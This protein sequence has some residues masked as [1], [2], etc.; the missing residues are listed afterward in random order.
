[1]DDAAANCSLSN[2][3]KEF[4][5]LTSVWTNCTLNHTDAPCLHCLV[6]YEEVNLMYNQMK[7]ARHDNI[8]FDIKD[9][10]NIINKKKTG[11]NNK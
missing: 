7:Q 5:N 2:N 3:T 9:S 10:V 4:M 8:C 11:E 6:Y 1:M